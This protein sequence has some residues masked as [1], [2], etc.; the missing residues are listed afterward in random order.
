MGTTDVRIDV[1]LNKHV[2]SSGIRSVLRRVRVR[3]ARKRNDEEDGEELYSL[4]T[5]AEIP[6][7][8]PLWSGSQKQRKVEASR[9]DGAADSAVV[10]VLPTTRS[11]RPPAPAHALTARSHH[12]A[13]LPARAC[14]RGQ[15]AGPGRMRRRQTG[16]RV[17]LL[18]PQHRKDGHAG[19][20]LHGSSGM[21]SRRLPVLL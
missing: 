15:A 14:G 11:R 9:S 16:T 17:R 2:W 12:G 18:F 1:K 7:E 19:A 20:L 4:V 5:V 3:I 21:A 13:D 8:G 6:P 10:L